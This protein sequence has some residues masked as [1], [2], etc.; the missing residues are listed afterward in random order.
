[1]YRSTENVSSWPQCSNSFYT[2]TK[3]QDGHI[4]QHVVWHSSDKFLTFNIYFKICSKTSDDKKD[5]PKTKIKYAKKCE[6][7]LKFSKA[8]DIQ[9]NLRYGH[10]LSKKFCEHIRKKLCL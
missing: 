2:V 7:S 9:S 1:M 4:C 6:K 8:V 5:K 10:Y 3:N